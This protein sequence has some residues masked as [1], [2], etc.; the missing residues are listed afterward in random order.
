MG[1]VAQAAQGE[2]I[3]AVFVILGENDGGVGVI[4][5]NECRRFV[6]AQQIGVDGHHLHGVG[7]FFGN[8]VEIGKLCH[9]GT[10]PGAPEVDDGDLTKAGEIHR[11]RLDA[12]SGDGGQGS[13]GQLVA[14]LTADLCSRAGGIGGRGGFGGLYQVGGGIPV[15]GDGADQHGQHH[16]SG[17]DTHEQTLV[18]LICL[19]FFHLFRGCL[20]GKFV[21]AQEQLG[22]LPGDGLGG[23][24][25]DTFAA[26]DALLVAYV[27]DI[28][29]AMGN[30]QIAVSALIFIHL[31]TEEGNLV[32]QAVQT[33]QGADETAEYAE[34]EH[35]AHHDAD[36]QH[37][38]P[39]EQ[40]AQHGEEAVVDLIAQQQQTAFDGAGGADVLT[41]SGGG[42]LAEGISNGD[43]QYKEHQ[44]DVLHKGENPG[45]RA[46]LQLGGL[47]L[48]QQV[49]D[50][51]KGTQPAADHS[52]EQ[53]GVQQQNAAHI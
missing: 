14:G 29:L 49:L 40:G 34:N 4:V 47:N 13:A 2:E 3:G 12:V 39:G 19:G 38:F 51:T 6:L 53:N 35:T 21:G 41:E 45:D 5:C 26:G 18:L 28:H 17:A 52:A 9:A 1:V 44:D 15:V 25:V 22:S 27:L 46:L 33:A 8:L 24:N 50:Q 42:C 10:A 37:E 48:I 31:H 36:H 43:D 20:Y 16:Y 7:I 32:E 23:A 30:A 11:F